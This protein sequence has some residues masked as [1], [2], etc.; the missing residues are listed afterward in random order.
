[1]LDTRN[2]RVWT[3][4]AMVPQDVQGVRTREET[5]RRAQRHEGRIPLQWLE[6]QAWL[7]RRLVQLSA[8]GQDQA[9][10]P[11]GAGQTDIQMK[12]SFRPA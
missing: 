5:N 3:A 4:L 7:Q 8:E 11:A 1:M 2:G 6:A 12:W 9:H 10:L